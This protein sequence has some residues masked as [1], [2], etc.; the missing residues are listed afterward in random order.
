MCVFV[1]VCVCVCVSVSPSSLSFPCLFKPACAFSI[2]PTA[3]HA[4]QANLFLMTTSHTPTCKQTLCESAGLISTGLCLCVFHLTN[5]S[6]SI[7]GDA[8]ELLPPQMIRRTNMGSVSVACRPL[9]SSTLHTDK[10]DSSRQGESCLNPLGAFSFLQ[11]ICCVQGV[12]RALLRLLTL[13]CHPPW[14]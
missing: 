11:D 2:P 5:L 3:N 13:H 12:N 1:C 8:A 9:S 14:C 7:S 10:C 6:G 4:T